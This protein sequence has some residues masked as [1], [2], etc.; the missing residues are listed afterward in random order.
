MS[1]DLKNRYY[2]VVQEGS[3][4][5]VSMVFT[6]LDHLILRHASQEEIVGVIEKLEAAEPKLYDEM[7]H[8]WKEGV[9]S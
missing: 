3:I 4:E 9:F 5:F 7:I 2:D 6:E 8:D 1:Q